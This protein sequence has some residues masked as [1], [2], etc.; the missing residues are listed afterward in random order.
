MEPIKRRGRPPNIA[1]NKWSNEIK[2]RHNFKLTPSAKAYLD[3]CVTT[4]G[5]ENTTDVLEALGRELV[6]IPK[7]EFMKWQLSAGVKTS[8]RW[9]QAKKLLKDWEKYLT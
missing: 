7:D 9:E 3:L 5:L 4:Y 6:I 1:R 2:Q 8:P